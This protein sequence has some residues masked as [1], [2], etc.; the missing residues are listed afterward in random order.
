MHASAKGILVIDCTEKKEQQ[1][2][3]MILKTSHAFYL[4]PGGNILLAVALRHSTKHM[5]KGMLFLC[6]K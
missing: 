4:I 2:K 6:S 1:L 3:Q 5:F